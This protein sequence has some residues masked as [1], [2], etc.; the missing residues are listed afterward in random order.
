MLPKNS[1]RLSYE[2]MEELIEYDPN[3]G[4]IRW[5]HR[6]STRCKIDWFPGSISKSGTGNYTFYSIRIQKKCYIVSN[7]AWLLMTKQWS[8][9]QIDH[10]DR[11]TL[12]NKWNNLSEATYSLQNM[13]RTVM[14]NNILGIKGV[15][16]LN[17][18]Y[19]ARIRIDGLLINLGHYNTSEEASCAYKFVARIYHGD[20]Y[21]E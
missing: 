19:V 2:E 12:N 1:D 11:N 7:I 5:L 13:N 10:K 9:N 21:A 18:K 6:T 15:R 8:Y 17:G 4:L 16:L 20:F 3:T 14:K